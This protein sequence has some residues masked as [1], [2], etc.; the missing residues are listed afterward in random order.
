MQTEYSTY[1]SHLDDLQSTYSMILH[2]VKHAIS[3]LFKYYDT[4]FID[5]ESKYKLSNYVNFVQCNYVTFKN[6]YLTTDDIKP[7]FVVSYL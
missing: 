6:R 7:I 3:S 4:H 1:Y 2:T 5:F